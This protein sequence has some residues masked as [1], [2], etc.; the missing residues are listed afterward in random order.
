MEKS[1]KPLLIVWQDSF[2]QHVA[3]ID[4][5]HRGVVAVINS[6]HYFIQQGFGL[7]DLMP[8]VSVLKSYLNFHFKTEEGILRA[9]ESASLEQYCE[10]AISILDEFDV[11]LR[12]GLRDDEPQLLL[13]FLKHWW[14]EHLQQHEQCAALWRQ[15]DGDFSR[16]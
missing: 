12:L 4:E 7:R 11:Q 2:L 1:Q 3:L 8:T 10:T 16:I 5:Q 15:W 14:L 13:I 9:M 6:L